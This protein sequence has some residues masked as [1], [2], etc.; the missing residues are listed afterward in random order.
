MPV[1][2]INLSSVVRV[3]NLDAEDQNQDVLGCGNL[4]EAE[5]LGIL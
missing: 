1:L 3:G 4:V 5:G 2:I